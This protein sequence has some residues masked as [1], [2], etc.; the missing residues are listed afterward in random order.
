MVI[1]TKPK[2]LKLTNIP[3]VVK[4]TKF[5]SVLKSLLPV[6]LAWHNGWTYYR[7]SPVHRTC[8]VPSPNYREIFQTCLVFDQTY[9]VNNMTIGI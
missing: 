3:R 6:R 4:E 7:T 9:P 8:P 1:L 5:Q 2:C